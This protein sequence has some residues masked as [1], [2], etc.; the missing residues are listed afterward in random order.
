MAAPQPADAAAERESGNARCR[1]SVRPASPGQRPGLR[2]RH[3]PRWPRPR[4]R[5]AAVRG[6]PGRRASPTDR[7]SRRRR[8]PHGRRHCGRRRGWIR[9][10]SLAARKSHGGHDIVS[11]LHWTMTT[12]GGRSCAFQTA[13][14]PSYPASPATRTS[15]TERR[16]ARPLSTAVGRRGC[17][18]RADFAMH[19]VIPS[20]P[21]QIDASDR[22]YGSATRLRDGLHTNGANV[23]VTLE[24]IA[25]PSTKRPIIALL[26]S[27]GNIAVRPLRPLRRAAVGRGSLCRH[28]HR[29]AGGRLLDVRIVAATDKPFR[30]FGNVLVE[31][32][33][34]IDDVRSADVVVV[35][36][37]Y[38]PI[39]TPPRG[40]YPT[41]DRLAANGCTPR[42]ARR[43]RLLGLADPRR[44]GPARRTGVRRT[45]GVPGS[46]PRSTTQR[47]VSARNSILVFAG[48]DARLI[49]AGGGTSWHDLALHLIARLCGTNHALR[50]AKVYLF[51]G[52]VDGQLPFAAMTRRIQKT[53]AVIGK[54]QEWIAR[55]LRV[56]QSGGGDG[57]AIGSQTAHVRA[58][59]PRGHRISAHGLCPRL[60]IEEAKQ[61]IEIETIGIDEIGLKVG[62]EDPT[63]FAGCSSARPASRR[64]PIAGNSSEFLAWKSSAPQP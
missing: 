57:R 43:V 15:P 1:K 60:R 42:L 40:R 24:A 64:R 5:R 6:R 8:I 31:P 48:E 18:E 4:P 50:T 63:F 14:A 2:D 21:V 29:R 36:D 34:A 11:A 7:S 33:A 26:A 12:G 13:R 37:I 30:C 3:R 62:Y 45:L 59:L 49:T 38:T 58:P 56:R 44:S 27:S 9:A 39:D 22:A 52:H 61:I 28:D 16:R 51:A 35:C 17:R 46:V 47:S 54:C 19:L 41:R 10:N 32:H 55:Q 20:L 25:M 53:D 23:T